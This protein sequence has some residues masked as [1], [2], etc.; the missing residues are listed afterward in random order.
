LGL[1]DGASLRERA[2]GWMRE[3][4]LEFFSDRVAKLAG[5]LGLHVC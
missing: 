1:A 4:S 3:R 5:P 2:L